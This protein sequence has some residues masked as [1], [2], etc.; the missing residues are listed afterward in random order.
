VAGFCL[1]SS[2]EALG[3]VVTMDVLAQYRRHGVASALLEAVEQ[4]LAASH[5]AEMWLETATDNDAAIAFWQ[6][7]GYRKQ[8]IR[9]D[10]Y[11]G[12]RDAFTMRKSLARSAT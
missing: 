4:R 7:H 10:Y 1:A 11:P 6:R 2:E 9:R 8:G 3:Y 12:G 5:V